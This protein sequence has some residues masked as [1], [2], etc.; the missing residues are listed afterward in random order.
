MR[1]MPPSA[2]INPPV[3]LP[4]PIRPLHRR[5]HVPCTVASLAASGGEA[6]AIRAFPAH[7]RAGALFVI[8][9]P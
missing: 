8:A 3:R 6:G 1:R 5:E 9:S 7:H 2:R 4:E